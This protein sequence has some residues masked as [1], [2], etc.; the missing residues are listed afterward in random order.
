MKAVAPKF[1]KLN[2]LSGLANLLSKERLSDTLK[3]CVLALLLA[4][5]G[6]LWMWAHREDFVR[7]QRVELSAAFHEAG[8]RSCPGCGCW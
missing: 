1:S 4:T 8:A 2:P 7:S 5:V 3:S 6:A